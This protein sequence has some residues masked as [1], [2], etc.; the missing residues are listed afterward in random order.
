MKQKFWKM[1]ESYHAVDEQHT[2][3]WWHNA[4]WQPVT[5]NFKD[6]FLD[7]PFKNRLP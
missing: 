5:K 7:L 3:T 2:T 1:V 6:S 4:E